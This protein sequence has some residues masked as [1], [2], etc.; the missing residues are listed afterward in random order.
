MKPELINYD[1]F[2]KIV[3]SEKQTRISIVPLFDHSR[4]APGKT[5]EVTCTPMEYTGVKDD[6]N[7]RVAFKLKAENGMMRFSYVFDGEQEHNITLHEIDVKN[8]KKIGDFRFYSLKKDLYSLR[9]YKGDFHIHSFRSDGMESPAYVAAAGRRIGLD[10][11]AA[12]AHGRY[13]TS[14]V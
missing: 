12:T 1:V 4:F 7:E 6:W 2:P 8:R 5:Y 9:P 11:I 14:L 10:F 13:E 3:L